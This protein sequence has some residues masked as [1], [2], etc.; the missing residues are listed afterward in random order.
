M[1]F[2][3]DLRTPLMMD[4]LKVQ[5]Y[6]AAGS[7]QSVEQPKDIESQQAAKTQSSANGCWASTKN[8]CTRYAKAA[9]EAGFGLMCAFMAVLAP[10]LS[11][12]DMKTKVFTT[13]AFSGLALWSFKRAVTHIRTA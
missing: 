4:E 12:D 2:N 7:P 8:C 3:P 6:Q 11:G 10:G 1:S 5:N 13:S 9:G